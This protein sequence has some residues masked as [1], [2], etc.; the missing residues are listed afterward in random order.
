MK[1]SKVGQDFNHI[2]TRYPMA[3]NTRPYPRWIA[4]AFW[5]GVAVVFATVVFGFMNIGG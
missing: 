5:V 1:A 3:I 2:G 4:L